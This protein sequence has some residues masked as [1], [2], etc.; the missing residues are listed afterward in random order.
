MCDRDGGADRRVCHRGGLYGHCHQRFYSGHHHAGG[1]RGGHS[2]G[3]EQPGRLPGRAG[4]AGSGPGGQRD[5]G[6]LRLLLR[7]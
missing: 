5:T 2:G 7:S 3:F 4:E 1:H 6:G